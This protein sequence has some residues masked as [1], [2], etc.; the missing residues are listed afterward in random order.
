MTNLVEHFFKCSQT[1]IFF[2]LFIHLFLAVLGLC[3]GI[4]FFSSCG[5][6]G[7]V[8]SCGGWASHC[9][10]FFCYGA[11]ALGTQA[12]AFVACSSV[13]VVL[14][15]CGLSC[16]TVRGIFL[17]QRWNPCPLH[18]QVDSL[19]LDQPHLIYCNFCNKFF[20]NT[21]YLSWMSPHFLLEK[22]FFLSDQ[23]LN[24]WNSSRS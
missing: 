15:R 13:V 20:V 11:S 4:D 16:S 2:K 1:I 8:S 24:R 14:N 5:E 22:G 7:L 19:P 23:I 17:D 21:R 12:S 3:C 10:G 9:S 18:W 6:W